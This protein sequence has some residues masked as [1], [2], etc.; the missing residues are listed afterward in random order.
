MINS[1]AYL[2]KPGE[3]KMCFHQDIQ[4]LYEEGFVQSI[5]KEVNGQY[6][7]KSLEVNFQVICTQRWTYTQFIVGR[8]AQPIH[9][10]Q[11]SLQVEGRWKSIVRQ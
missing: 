1:L 8:E 9:Q 5:M 3:D 4:Q 7:K 11:T 2:S 10:D 6:D